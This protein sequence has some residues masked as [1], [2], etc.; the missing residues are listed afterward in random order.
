[1]AVIE[2]TSHA[3]FYFMMPIVYTSQKESKL[4]AVKE[5]L[6][7]TLKNASPNE[8]ELIV[9]QYAIQYH[10]G[11]FVNY[12]GITYNFMA[13][14]ISSDEKNG[15]QETVRTQWGVPSEDVDT[16]FLYLFQDF[17]TKTDSQLNFGS[18]FTTT[19][20]K[21]C[22]LFLLSALQPVSEAKE[23]VIVFLP[24][25]LLLSLL[26]SVLF[27]LL[28][29]GKITKPLSEI[30]KMT[31]RMKA[32]DPSAACRADTRDDLGILSENVNMLYQS[33]LSTID[34]L[35]KENVR[36]GEAEAA[37]VEF[38][39]AASH[40]LKTPVTALGGMIDSMIMG[41]GRYK[42]WET[43]LPVCRDLV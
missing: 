28:Y 32:L 21:P 8:V 31:E 16:D 20:G 26:L 19:D 10:L 38:L 39:R 9:R 35:Q 7:E 43:Y 36:A 15:S 27:A 22:Y 6:M 2:L 25:T 12:D 1:M 13:D 42:D 41:I 33:L 30:S 24:L 29:S 17:Y 18:R 37:K 23:A 5:Q 40:E 3:L 34:S 4:Q 14:S 11:I